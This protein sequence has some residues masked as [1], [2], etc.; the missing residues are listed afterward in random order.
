MSTMGLPEGKNNDNWYGSSKQT[1]KNHE[2]SGKFEI[3][4]SRVLG[5]S[6]KG[7]PLETKF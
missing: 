2:V 6:S 5:A 1:I 7:L 3:K 4:G